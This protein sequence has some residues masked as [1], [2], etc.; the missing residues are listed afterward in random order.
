MDDIGGLLAIA[1]ANATNI[2]DSRGLLGFLNTLGGW[3]LRAAHAA[4]SN[5]IAGAALPSGLLQHCHLMHLTMGRSAASRCTLDSAQTK[6]TEHVAR[7]DTIAG[8]PSCARSFCAL[9]WALSVQGGADIAQR[10]FHGHTC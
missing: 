10:S 8:A 1:C 9:L 7:S 3:A 2:E 6:C 4:R 5:T